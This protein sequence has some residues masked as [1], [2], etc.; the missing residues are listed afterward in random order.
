MSKIFA[1]AAFAIPAVLLGALSLVPTPAASPAMAAT[2]AQCPAFLDHEFRK[3]HSGQKVNLCKSFAGKPL[4]I[5]NTASH[6]GFT[7]QFKGLE[8]LHTKYKG[9]GL[10]VV[11]FASDDFNQEDKDESKVADTC[12]LNYGVTFTMLA[13]QHVKG[14]EANPV[15]AEL[16]R[17]TEEPSW[18]FNKYLVSADGRTMQHFGSKVTPESPEL[19]AAIDALLK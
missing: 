2:A 8:A 12:F 11:G 3:L 14:P 19:T 4:L 17:R 10:N 1:P 9:R 7:P 6:C 13:P 15:F 5:V 16:G 18:N